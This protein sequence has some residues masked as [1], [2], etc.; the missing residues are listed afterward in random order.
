MWD[1][2]IIGSVP[3][4]VKFA[5]ERSKQW[6]QCEAFA[7]QI[8]RQ[9]PPPPRA[10]AGIGY[11]H[12]GEATSYHVIVIFDAHDENGWQWANDVKNDIKGV[13]LEWDETVRLHLK[14]N[15]NVRI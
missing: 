13:L 10:R 12:L 6:T 9:Y 14:E 4:N 11:E 15:D 1:Y 7:S 5:K 3:K 8:E 2:V